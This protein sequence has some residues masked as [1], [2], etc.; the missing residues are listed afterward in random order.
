MVT[1]SPVCPVTS[2]IGERTKLEKSSSASLMPD[3]AEDLR[4]NAESN[5]SNG[6][7]KIKL[8][9]AATKAQAAFR[10]YLVILLS[11]IYLFF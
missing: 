6:E 1:S 10:G 11:L 3:T 2:S 9:Q 8:E 4:I 7:D 5:A